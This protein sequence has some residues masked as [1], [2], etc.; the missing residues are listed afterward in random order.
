MVE[1]HAA[2]AGSGRLPA[3]SVIARQRERDER[4]CK[5]FLGKQNKKKK[6]KN[7]IDSEGYSGVKS[8]EE[9]HSTINLLLG[10]TYV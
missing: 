7:K 5:I 9:K 4:V 8:Q 2:F 6:R 1:Q 3:E 10:N